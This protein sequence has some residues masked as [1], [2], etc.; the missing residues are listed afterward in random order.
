[1]NQSQDNTPEHL[2]IPP[3]LANDPAAACEF[4]AARF[5]ALTGDADAASRAAKMATEAQMGATGSGAQQSPSASSPRPAAAKVEDTAT[6]AAPLQDNDECL[7]LHISECPLC[8]DDS[9]VIQLLR[10]RLRSACQV[11]APDSLK[12]RIVTH[13]TAYTYIDYK[14]KDD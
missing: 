12:M 10:Q 4:L 14:E 9:P 3:E 1:M 6:T 13:I 5:F 8:H 2:R 11:K 7:T